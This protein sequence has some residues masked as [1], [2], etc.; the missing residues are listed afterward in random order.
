VSTA[1]KIFN[2]IDAPKKEGVYHRLIC[3]T[4]ENK[5][6]AYFLLGN[7]VVM[8]RSETTD[9]MISDIKSSREHA[10]IIKVGSSFI[11][12]DLGSQNG[13]IVNDLKIK[14]HT[15]SNGDKIIIGKTVYKFS[16]VEVKAT[17]NLKI[18]TNSMSNDVEEN[19]SESPEIGKPNKKINVIILILII[20]VVFFFC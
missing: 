4:G 12:T 14:Q 13:V 17:K 11:I 19:D 1:V 7:R 15:L 18:A 9:I 3:L 6:K 10:E 2:H 8:G 5:G 16:K 20:G